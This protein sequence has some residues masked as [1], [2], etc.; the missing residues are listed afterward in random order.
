MSVPVKRE[1][2]LI[3]PAS[4]RRRAGLRAGD[5]VEFKVSSR[6]ITITPVGPPSYKPT[7]SELAAIQ[8]GEAEI[9]RGDYVTLT[10]LLHDL[11]RPDR[12]GRAKAARKISGQRPD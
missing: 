10:D 4:V 5:K 6:T 12:K 7:K 11:D 8:K 9:A 2:D 1:T 3:V